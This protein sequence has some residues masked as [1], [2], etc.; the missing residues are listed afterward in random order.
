MAQVWSYK[1]LADWGIPPMIGGTLNINKAIL[2]SAV[3]PQ[4]AV[5]AGAKLDVS[6]DLEYVA[7]GTVE[8]LKATADAQYIHRLLIAAGNS[9]ADLKVLTWRLGGSNITVPAA[10][11]NACVMTG[12]E[13][14]IVLYGWD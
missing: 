10:V 7:F 14:R 6:S 2:V 5:A 3:G 4:T 1:L 12:A 13:A 8:S 9:G 11:S